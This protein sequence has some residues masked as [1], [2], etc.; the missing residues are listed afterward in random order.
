MANFKLFKDLGYDK[1]KLAEIISKL[2]DLLESSKVN[3]VEALVCAW[4]LAHSVLNNAPAPQAVTKLTVTKL[5][6]FIQEIFLHWKVKEPIK[7]GQH[8]SRMN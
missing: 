8:R 7:D 4:G 2:E 5:N 3:H 1:E 6:N